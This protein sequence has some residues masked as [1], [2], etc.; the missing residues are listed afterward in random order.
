[1]KK[2]IIISFMVVLILGLNSCGKDSSTSDNSNIVIY[3]VPVDAA[4]KYIALAFCNASAGINYHIENVIAY[5]AQGRGSFDSVFTVKK[6]DTAATIKYQ[7]QVEYTLARF[8]S[9]PP[10]VDFDYSAGG[11]FSSNAMQ[12]EDEQTGSWFFSTLD[13]SKFTLTGSGSDGGKQY[14]VLDKVLFTSQFNYTLQN[15][16]V[17]KMTDMIDSGTAAISISGAGPA[18]VH[19]NYS[20]TLTFSGNRKAVLVLN[21]STFNFSLLTGGYT[22]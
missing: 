21:G 20:G 5:I 12:S 8:T 18:N 11:S 3:Q 7:Y 2:L 16:M 1:M 19:F 9:V 10:T 22:K 13:Q 4:G 6:L 15:V 17:N 14:S